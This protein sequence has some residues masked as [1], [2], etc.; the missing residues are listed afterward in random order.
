M[1]KLVNGDQYVEELEQSNLEEDEVFLEDGCL[2][3]EC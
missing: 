3:G 1:A 2:Q